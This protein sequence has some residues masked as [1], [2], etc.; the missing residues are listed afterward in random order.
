ML[1]MMRLMSLEDLEME[2]EEVEA[3]AT[4]LMET[5]DR[6]DD[7]SMVM[8][9]DAASNHQGEMQDMDCDKYYDAASN[10]MGRSSQHGEVERIEMDTNY[11]APSNHQRGSQVMHYI[12]DAPSTSQGSQYDGGAVGLGSGWRNTE[13][14]FGNITIM[15]SRWEAQEEE[16]DT[17]VVEMV[18]RR[19]RSKKLDKIVRELNLESDEDAL[20]SKEPELENSSRGIEKQNQT[21][22][23]LK[24]EPKQTISLWDSKRKGGGKRKLETMDYGNYGRNEAKR[25]CGSC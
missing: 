17:P 10:S 9:N 25:W 23:N 22:D 2:V 14:E 3:M 11:D 5:E 12:N 4:E 6:S 16:D 20:V 7:C 15:I 18:R 21:K 19:R 8:D 24:P 13:E 1:R